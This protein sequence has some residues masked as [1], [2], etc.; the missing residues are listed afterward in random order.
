[1]RQSIFRQLVKRL[2]LDSDFE[3]VI[4]FSAEYETED[5]TYFL[6]FFGDSDNEYRLTFDSCG[7]VK[8]G[9]YKKVILT[10]EQEKELSKILKKKVN[11]TVSRLKEERE[12]EEFRD[13][14]PNEDPYWENG[15]KRSD[16]I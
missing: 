6:N 11:E 14:L 3:D 15:V 12:N 8:E 5:K 16:F 10:E 1:M 4:G 13:N 2:E 9:D 7:Y